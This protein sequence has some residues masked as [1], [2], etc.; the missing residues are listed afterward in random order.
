MA[1]LVF[2]ILLAAFLLSALIWHIL[3]SHVRRLLM[4]CH[5][6]VWDEMCKRT[7]NSYTAEIGF[8]QFRRDRRLNDAILTRATRKAALAYYIT[9]M[10]FLLLG[11]LMWYQG[12]WW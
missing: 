11:W 5:P 4:D 7:F 3:S 2:Y 9:F 12:K 6:G 8:I 1:M 10:F